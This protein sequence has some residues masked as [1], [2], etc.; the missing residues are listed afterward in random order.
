MKEPKEIQQQPYAVKNVRKTR[1]A[2]MTNHAYAV[3]VIH[4][5]TG[6]KPMENALWQ[7]E[8]LFRHAFDHA[9]IGKAVVALQGRWLRVNR[10][11]CEITGYTEAELLATDWQTVTHP[12]DRAV[13]LPQARRL[14]A[15]EID[16]YTLTKRYL[17]KERRIVWTA[18]TVALVCNSDG[19]P[20]CFS[21]EIQ[22]RTEQKQLE[23]QLREQE[24]LAIVGTTVVKIA[25][26]IGNPL[27]G[28]LTTLQGLEW[29]IKEREL[30]PNVR[31]I[32]AVYDLRQETNRLRSLLQE[33]RD[34]ARPHELDLQP[35][36]LSEVVAQVLRGQMASYENQN[37][38]VVQDFP[39]ALPL[40]M[41]DQE[42]LAQV[43]LNLCNNAVEAM[44]AG[45][46]LTV[47]GGY[48]QASVYLE[49]NDTGEGITPDVDVFM[50]FVTTKAQGSGFG[51]AIVK[52]IVET[53][54]G[55]ISYSS[56]LDH[57]TSFRITL[58]T[59]E[60]DITRAE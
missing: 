20:L 14:L 36:Q 21:V 50:P 55:V 30:I 52:Q 58:P 5:V 32:E 26:E 49:V 12:E 10:R 19:T 13:E 8:E 23:A 56:V 7:N 37:V 3:M 41:A 1:T 44:P 15:K 54:G 34:F 16:S 9:A 43:V 35:I 18:A 24:R 40:V 27:N 42:K 28:M 6:H 46:T 57:G 48:D 29:E 33:L 31:L 25:H 39:L 47:R 53:H 4:D 45:G 11:L 17:H 38:L 2:R 59:T 51:L 60:R 22:D